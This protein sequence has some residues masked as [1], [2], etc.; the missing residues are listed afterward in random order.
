MLQRLSI[1]YK[2]GFIALIGFVGLVIFQAASYRLSIN[3]R[4][5]LQSIQAE[6]FVLLKFS[7]DIQVSFSNL[8][9]LYQ[10]SLAEADIDTLME[11]DGNATQMKL[12]FESM[13]DSFSHSDPLF[14]ELQSVF[15]E[16]V[17]RTSAHTAAVLGN[18]LDYE[19]TLE[20]YTEIGLLRQRYEKLQAQLLEERYL[21]FEKQLIVIEEEE[22]F[23]VAFGLILGL[24][25]TSILLLVSFI[26]IRHLISALNNAVTVAEQIANGNL[27]Q[28]IDTLAQDETGQLMQSLQAMRDVLKAQAQDNQQREVIQVFLAGLNETM[29]GDQ[30]PEKLTAA[31][32]AYLAQHFQAQLGAI[33]LLSSHNELCRVAAYAYPSDAFSRKTFR[34]GET[35]IG[36]VALEKRAKI[37]TAVPEDFVQVCTGIGHAPPKSIMLIPVMFENRLQGL[38]ELASFSVFTPADLDL[39]DRCNNAIATAI[40]SAQ[41][42]VQM[43]E[44]LELEQMQA[45]EL[46]SQRQALATSNTALAERSTEL[47]KQNTQLEKSRVALLDKSRALEASGRYKSQFLSTMSHELRTP[48]NSILILSEALQDNRHQHLSEKEVQHAQVINT[49]GEDLLSLINDILDLSKVEEGKMELIVEALKPQEFGSYISQLFDY[50]AKD[51]GLQFQVDVDAQL[52]EYFYTDKQRLTQIVKNFVSNALKF[53]HRGGIYLSITKPC[54]G[55]LP[56]RKGLRPDNA[57]LIKVRDTGIGIAKEKQGLVFEAF[58]QADGTT[59]RKYGGTGLG[60]TI[61]MELAKLLGGEIILR[62]EEGKGAEFALIIPLGSKEQVKSNRLLESQSSTQNKALALDGI[63]LLSSELYAKPVDGELNDVLLISA[64]EPLVQ[65]IE[66]QASSSNKMQRYQHLQALESEA[67]DSK[68]FIVD[69]A[70]LDNDDWLYLQRYLQQPQARFGVLLMIADS[71]EQHRVETLGALFIERDVF[72]GC[73]EQSREV[74]KSLYELS[75]ETIRR[76]LVVEDNPVF[77]EVIRVVFNKN[78]VPLSMAKNGAQALNLLVSPVFSSLI[79]DLNLPDYSDLTLLQRIRTIPH[80][81][82]TPITIFTAEDVDENRLEKIHNYANQLVLKSPKAISEIC[83]QAKKTLLQQGVAERLFEGGTCVSES[84]YQTGDLEGVKVL[85]VDDDARNLYSISHAL[86]SEGLVVRAVSSGAQ[87]LDYLAQHDDIKLLLLDIMMPDMDGYQVLDKLKASPDVS[88]LPVIALTA[89]AMPDDKARCISAGACDYFS[90]PIDVPALLQC[91]S[92][93]LLLTPEQK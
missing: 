85:L 31:I 84:V 59:S 46:K 76:V 38:I 8:D 51:K 24:V 68:L 63:P 7:N 88:D 13:K 29:R 74:F 22:A 40:A 60:L 26:I 80:Y 50:I 65:M 39:F 35:M 16:Y 3:I 93:H 83:L 53:T 72:L 37:L 58:K 91:I 89:K 62:S 73:G 21:S 42:R 78:A 33:F 27:N 64:S 25:F 1:R 14:N 23:L 2:I 45:A 70:E 82:L 87:A 90:K 19:R 75:N 18:N 69:A 9:K 54:A 44:I 49:A 43:A 5:Q 30:S 32:L 67:L 28:K 11:A 20:G 17:L 47:D 57:L 81:R 36:Q 34:L 55:F 52:A 48:L 56:T 15:S 10:A 66:T 41:S 86:E 61:S 71:R 4:D 92:S 79:V 12:Q 77:N 6:D